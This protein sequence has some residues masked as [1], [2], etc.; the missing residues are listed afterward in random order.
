M[1]PTLAPETIDTIIDHLHSDRT[2]LFAC[3]LTAKQW[4]PTT[5]FHIFAKVH[6]RPANIE[7][8]LSLLREPNS[9]LPFMMRH[10]LVNGFNTFIIVNGYP[11][12][13]DHLNQVASLL[14]EVKYLRLLNSSEATHDIVSQMPKI[15]DLEVHTIH[16]TTMNHFL[17][18][19]YAFPH[20][21]AV[22]FAKCIVTDSNL[23]PREA[24]PGTG[25]SFIIRN[26]N[27]RVD[28]YY[29]LGHWLMALRPVPHIRSIHFVE[30]RKNPLKNNVI[31][32]LI[33]SLI[34]GLTLDLRSLRDADVIIGIVFG[35][36]VSILAINC[37]HRQ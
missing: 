26:L 4:L 33:G 1:T 21:E 27:A 10:L 3:S 12:A 34:M 37:F 11:E 23:V 22:S 35:L 25:T 29:P 13:L 30:D 28:M 6:I 36:M 20:L 18:L 19:V 15:V 8:F 2:S 24:L 16:F 14:R 7:S 32:Q 5:R 31:L 17:D 9:Q